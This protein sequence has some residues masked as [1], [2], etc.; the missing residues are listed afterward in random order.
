MPG[1]KLVLDETYDL[2]GLNQ[3]M[4]DMVKPT[5]ESPY[6]INFRMYARDENDTRVA[7]R[8]RKGS[9]RIT[10]AIGETLDAQNVGASTGDLAFSTTRIIAQPFTAGASGSLSRLDFEIKKVAGSTGHIIVQIC[11]N[12]GGIPG[13]VIGT[14]SILSSAVSTAYAY[15]PAYLMDAPG[16]V[17]GTQYW[18]LLYVQDNGTGSYYVNQTADVGALDLQSTNEQQTWSSIGASFHFK[19]YIA[20]TAGVKGYHRRYPSNG[21]KRTLF[22]A[23]GSIYEV[24]DN[25]T[26]TEIDNTLNSSSDYVR[27]DFV[28]DK[29]FY[30]NG[31]N[32][33]RQWDGA[34]ASNITGAPVGA[35]LVKIHQGR[36]FFLIDKTK[37]VFSDLYDFNSYPSVNF[38]YVPDPKSADGVTGAISFHDDLLIFT[39]ETKHQ[40]IGSDISSFTRKEAEGT[41]GAVCD[42]AI[43]ADRNYAFFMADDGSI[44][45]WNGASDILMSDKIE[46]ELAAIPDKT[47]VRFHLYRN[48]LRVYYASKTSTF[49]DRMAVCDLTYSNFKTRDFRWYIDTGR[50]VTGSLEWNQD[51]GNDLI[52]FSSKIGQMYRGETTGSDMGKP[53]DF[54]YWTAYK[55]YGSGSAKKR[56]KRF[57]PIVRTGESDYTL[58][59]GKDADFADSPDMRAYIV[60]GGG[61]KFGSFIWGDGTLWGRTKMVDRPSGMSGRG[62]HIQYRFER[63]GVETPVELYGYIA[64]VKVG[65]PK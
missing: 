34:N 41:K 23:G 29:S 39:H 62:N 53:I 6:A 1:S 11:A 19:S 9:E 42:E 12:N 16:V 56:I 50:N 47:K 26:I 20:T 46:P 30:V 61:A 54:K 37:F 15:L 18:A 65:K 17:N 59:I 31:L 40:L 63:S 8:T 57:R 14:T 35:A 36:A 49:N 44:N 52:E 13:Q 7:I 55:T 10:T 5:G 43:A 64:Q 2:R 51:A 45:A 58:S 33:P 28:D 32:V 22:A 3:V 25:G 24:Q 21:S 27:F 60:S 48:Q 4:P 38:F